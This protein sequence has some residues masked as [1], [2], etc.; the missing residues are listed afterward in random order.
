MEGEGDED[1][2]DNNGSTGDRIDE[3]MNLA[4]E[5]AEHNDEVLLASSNDS[6][7]LNNTDWSK[8]KI[9]KSL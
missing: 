7:Q 5:I 9:N 6:P 1:D 8:K 4:Q 3:E 2:D